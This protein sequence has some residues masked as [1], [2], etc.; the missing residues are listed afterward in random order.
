[1]YISF[2][3]NNNTK[4]QQINFAQCTST[5]HIAHIHTQTHSCDTS[6]QWILHGNF[7]CGAMVAVHLCRAFVASPVAVIAL[8]ECHHSHIASLTELP[9]CS[10]SFGSCKILFTC[11]S[12]RCYT[13]PK[14]IPTLLCVFLLFSFP[15]PLSLSL[16]IQNTL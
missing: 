3:E 13:R 9:N 15:P 6:F 1:M 14:Y 5:T 4:I 12:R 10:S 16:S 8:T 7:T 2:C 11:F